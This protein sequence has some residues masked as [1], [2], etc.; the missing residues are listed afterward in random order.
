MPTNPARR[1]GPFPH[2]ALST[3][4]KLDQGRQAVQLRTEG[5]SFRQIAPVIGVSPATAWRRFWWLLDATVPQSQGLSPD[6]RLPQR[7]TSAHPSGD[8]PW[9]DAVDGP[10]KRREPSR[11][12][13][14]ARCGA[15][16]RTRG[17]LPCRNWPVRGARRCRMHGCG[18]SRKRRAP[19][20]GEG[21]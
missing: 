12:P 10:R 19:A 18:G 7:H 6:F 15:R 9:I 8:R 17:G 2:L 11:E 13:V 16:A 5:W 21:S 4:V 20:G 3:T 1:G 14:R